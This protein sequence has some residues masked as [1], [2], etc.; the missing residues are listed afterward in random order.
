MVQR[1]I[2]SDSMCVT[3][4]S[5][6]HDTV[7]PIISGRERGVKSLLKHV[8]SAIRLPSWDE[9]VF[10]CL[11]RRNVSVAVHSS[12]LS[13]GTNHGDTVYTKLKELSFN[14]WKKWEKIDKYFSPAA[15]NWFFVSASF[16][17]W[18]K[19]RKHCL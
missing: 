15:P 5:V 2:W 16:L 19:H 11:T 14:K 17:S 18:F 6:S 8:R 12:S 10:M 1:F 13:R 4:I 7:L 3:V 9:A